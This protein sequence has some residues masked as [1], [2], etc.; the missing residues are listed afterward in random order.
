MSWAQDYA[1]A[2]RSSMMDAAL[3]EFFRFVGAGYEQ[4]RV[5]CHHNFTERETH[6]GR[7][8]WITRKGAIRA[9]VG[10][11]GVI[12]GSMGTRSYIVSG[13]GNPL[14]YNS[15]SHGAGR[16]YSRSKAKQTFTVDDL[17]EQMKGKTWLSGKAEALLDEIPSSYKDIDV[18]MN[19]QRDL[20]KIEHTL[21]QVL[22]YKGPES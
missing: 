11:R 21:T 13:R 17:A 19:D 9:D 20:V 4:D 15:C 7:G 16:R 5:N 14:S 8:L 2:N 1:M 6:A 3:V 18:V 10:D 22:N 12:P